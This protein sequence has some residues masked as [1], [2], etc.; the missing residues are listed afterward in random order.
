MITSDIP[1]GLKNPAFLRRRDFFY[2]PL[3]LCCYFAGLLN[4][5]FEIHCGGDL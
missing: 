3:P 1:L 4:S 5:N 2:F